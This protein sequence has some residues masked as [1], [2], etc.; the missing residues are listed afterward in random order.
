MTHLELVVL[1]LQFPAQLFQFLL[2]GN[3]LAQLGTARVL[4]L[5]QLIASL[6]ILD[7][8]SF[9]TF[10]IRQEFRTSLM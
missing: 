5:L 9:M 1:L 6:L 4:L 2:E 7:A 10:H 3:S 8:L